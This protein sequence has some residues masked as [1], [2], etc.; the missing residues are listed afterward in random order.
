MKFS[1]TY[2]R[3]IKHKGH[4]LTGVAYKPVEPSVSAQPFEA[5]FAGA[6]TAN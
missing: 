2:D 1:G 6:R 4:E 5:M 3:N